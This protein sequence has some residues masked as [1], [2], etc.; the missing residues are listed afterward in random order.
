M[1]LALNPHPPKEKNKQ[2]TNKLLI[3]KDKRI[4]HVH[5]ETISVYFWV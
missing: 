5:R 4:E 3:V 2:K 1:N